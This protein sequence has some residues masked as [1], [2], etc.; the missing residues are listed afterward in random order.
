M[1]NYTNASAR[2]PK[3]TFFPHIIIAV[4]IVINF[5]NVFRCLYCVCVCVW[6]ALD[7]NLYVRACEC[8]LARSRVFLYVWCVQV[9]VCVRVCE[10]FVAYDS[11]VCIQ[12]QQ[13]LEKLRQTIFHTNTIFSS[14]SNG[15]KMLLSDLFLC[16]FGFSHFLSHSFACA[17]VSC[18]CCC[19]CY[20][21]RNKNRN[22]DWCF[23]RMSVN[24]VKWNDRL[25]RMK[26]FLNGTYLKTI[27]KRVRVRVCNVFA[28]TRENSTWIIAS[29]T[30]MNAGKQAGM[31]TKLARVSH[32]VEWQK[33]CIERWIDRV[34]ERME[35]SE[36]ASVL[37][38][39]THKQKPN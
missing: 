24:C 6:R 22:V 3:G 14:T 30:S 27:R 7:E 1:S 33:V 10:L 18:C 36:R 23:I 25:L 2:V 32:C 17:C 15:F 16:C 4:I 5:P 38:M 19:C 35:P 26:K 20:G 8:A 13:K 12:W 39:K 37:D 34:W 11:M 29:A 21:E 28:A 9:W 31:F